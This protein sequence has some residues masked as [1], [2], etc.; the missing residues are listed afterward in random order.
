MGDPRTPMFTW[1]IVGA[2]GK[3]PGPR[4]RHGLAYDRD[5]G[6]IVL[7]GGA[8]WVGGGRARLPAD[9]WELRDGDWTRIDAPSS[10]SGR[11]RSGMVFDDAR[12]FTVLFG[13]GTSAATGARSRPV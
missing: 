3:G 11:H 7:F 9:T 8:V 2:D 13:G 5:A 4:S 1:Q 10:P 6:A 12:G